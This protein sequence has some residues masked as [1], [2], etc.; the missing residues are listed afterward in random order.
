MQGLSNT[1]FE[2]KLW[3][4][5][6]ASVFMAAG[7]YVINDYFDTGIDKI[8]KAGIRVLEKGLSRKSAL[9]LYFILTIPAVFSGFYISILFFSIFTAIA[10]TLFLYSRYLKGIPLLGNAV[11]AIL[12]ALTVFLVWLNKSV[13]RL[14]LIVFFS[15]FSF[16]SGMFREI[17]KDI[18]DQEGD[19]HMNVRT[20]PVVAG[21]SF[22][23]NVAVAFAVL[24]LTTLIISIVYIGFMNEIFLLISFVFLFFMLLSIIY[25]FRQAESIEDY[26]KTSSLIKIFVVLGIISMIFTLKQ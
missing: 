16:L 14:D 19:M 13:G 24:L 17:V 22:A 9:V 18:E 7:G 5:M 20:L 25:I 11:V 1:V 23:K 15:V 26:H 10:I 8:N 2:Y 6:A 21:I 3:I 4:L 12:L